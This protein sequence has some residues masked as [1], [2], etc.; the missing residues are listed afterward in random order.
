MFDPVANSVWTIP[1]SRFFPWGFVVLSAALIGFM[2]DDLRRAAKDSASK[3]DRSMKFAPHYRE[4]DDMSVFF[5]S[6][7]DSAAYAADWALA[8]KQ[9]EER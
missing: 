1:A 2:V 5:D 3:N 8:Q 4:E 6:G 7:D 9:R